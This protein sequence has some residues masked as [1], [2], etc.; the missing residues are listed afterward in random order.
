M[1]VQPSH[2]EVFAQVDAAHIGV[3][4]NVFGCALG[5]HAAFADD[6]SVVANAQGF[7]HIVVGDQDT[8][9]TLLQESDDALN[10]NDGNGINAGK[11]FV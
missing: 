7:A 10:F 4:H 2:S 11:G 6:V 8:N 1:L 5:Q 3:V 9:A